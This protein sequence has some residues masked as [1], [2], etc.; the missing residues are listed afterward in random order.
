LKTI[1]AGL[2]LILVTTTARAEP[3]PAGAKAAVSRL[4]EAIRTSDQAHYTEVGS[5]LVIMAAPD[6]GVSISF[7]EARE[8]FASCS[9]TSLSDPR[10]V[11]TSIPAY[12]VTAT[13]TCSAPL[14]AGPITFDFMADAV[15]VYGI[16]PGGIDRFYP[17]GRK[18]AGAQP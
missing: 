10:P 8:L 1:V 6:F 5:Q 2:A 13:M 14:P 11:S 16:Y 12:I 18:D 9:S 15:Q 7:A 3:P 17:K 4:L